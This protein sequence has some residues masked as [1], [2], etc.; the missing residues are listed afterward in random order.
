MVAERPHYQ[1]P[2]EDGAVLLDP[3]LDESPD[4][5]RRNVAALAGTGIELAGR[6]LSELRSASRGSAVSAAC[7]YL[8]ELGLPPVA[9][10]PDAPL[11]VTGHQPTF[12]HPG[13]WFKNFLTQWLARKTG[14]TALNLVVD[15]DEARDLGLSVPVHA[16]GQG[17]RV[18]VALGS[19]RPQV[20]CEEGGTKPG[21][22]ECCRVDEAR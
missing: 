5:V 1:V 11:V 12:Y 2:T 14:G 15:N 17:T 3:A 6:P 16:G 21:E 9:T 22:E 7:R 13:I 19:A 8:D 18:D 10:T 4:L 20:A